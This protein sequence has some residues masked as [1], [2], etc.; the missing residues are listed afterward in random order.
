[1]SRALGLYFFIMNLRKQLEGAILRGSDMRESTEECKK[2]A[3]DH[4]IAF[5]DWCLHIKSL[6]E[7]K[8]KLAVDMYHDFMKLQ[9]CE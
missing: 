2:V 3:T 7:Y 1:M 5:A 6:E 8:D 9:N 4:A